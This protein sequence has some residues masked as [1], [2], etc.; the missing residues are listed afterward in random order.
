MK[1]QLEQVG[2]S[3]SEASRAFS[4]QKM[5]EVCSHLAQAASMLDA[6]TA[7]IPAPAAEPQ[8]A[9]ATRSLA[10]VA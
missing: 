1:A 2:C 9:E 7:L 4:A 6:L 3:L 10:M 5:E 8:Q